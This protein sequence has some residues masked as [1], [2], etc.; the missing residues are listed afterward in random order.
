MQTSRRGSD[1]L[2]QL[3]AE[4]RRAAQQLEQE[5][6]AWSVRYSRAINADSTI[7]RNKV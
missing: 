3:A 4:V 7:P 6:L 1:R 2:E 5:Q